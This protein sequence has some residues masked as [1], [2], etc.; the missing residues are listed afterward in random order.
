MEAAEAGPSGELPTTYQ[1]E[2]SL[3]VKISKIAT[4]LYGGS[5]VNYSSAAEKK[6][7]EFEKR[8]FAD[9]RICM[10]KTQYS[11]SDDADRVG[12]PKD[13]ELEIREVRL[14]AGAGFVIP[15]SGDMMTMPGLASEPNLEKID[16]DE[17][18]KAILF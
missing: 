1:N 16:L 3:K 4:S 7:H 5:G 6:L 18:G 14:A 11:F 17:N 13:F 15:I 12:R 2:D 8:G 10:A 9:S